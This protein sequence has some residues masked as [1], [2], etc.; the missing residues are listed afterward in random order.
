VASNG[1]GSVMG[2]VL[3]NTRIARLVVAYAAFVLSEYAT[4]IAITVLAFE[5][6]GAT[7]AGIVALAQLVPA[8]VLA[9]VLARVVER[10]AERGSPHVRVVGHLVQA[11]GLATAAV[12]AAADVVL[13]A[14]AGAVLT[15]V[16]VA[17]TRP[18]QASMLPSVADTPEQL[19]AA[20]VA[21]G[22]V[23]NAGIALAGLVAGA[24]LAVSDPALTLAVGSALMVTAALLLLPP[25]QERTR[26][27]QANRPR[28]A[29]AERGSVMGN[30]AAVLLLAMLTMQWLVIGALDVLYVVLAVDVMDAG[31]A[32]VGYLQA[33]FGAGALVA[34]GLAALL[35]GK[36]LGVPILLSALV[37]SVALMLVAL[38]GEIVLAALLLGT[39]GA[40]RAVLDVSGRTLLQR[41]VPP[42]LLSH[43]FGAL[44]GL[45]MAGRAVGSV[46]VPTL[47]ALGGSDAAVVGVAAVM[48]VAAV[49]AGGPLLTVD[50]RATVPVVEIALLRSLRLF[51][52]LGPPAL[53]ALARALE[54][55]D[56]EAG[57]TLI[58]EG[59]VGDSYY[60]IGRG[61]F[62]V[63]RE[64]RDLGLR[65]RG[66]GVGEIALLRDIPRTATITAA[67]QATVYV[68][69]R[70][71]FLTTVT[72][73]DPTR[74]TAD[75]IV[76]QRLRD[77]DPAG[78]AG[79]GPEGQ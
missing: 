2:D 69:D 46:L 43:T 34:S 52:G 45:S 18:A 17:T 75:V 76:E 31:E 14:Y 39:A 20:N 24:L 64:G 63:T 19:T 15:S 27:R 60:V 78:P 44:E 51:T 47:L 49:V 21:L 58:T 40:G 41:A 77:E 53:E 6:G 62:T 5:R 59:E 66:D 13:V 11:A 50:S 67:G 74:T 16:A 10:A 36:R 79:T 28:E 33:S 73:H 26:P 56:V 35:V 7:E 22:W 65:G 4:W 72:G 54:R 12:A 68:L 3:G 1:S 23:E 57:T 55:R 37:Q 38:T 25:K 71:S 48:L 61:E 29:D 42:H 32:W 70:E 8:A 9:P 30:E